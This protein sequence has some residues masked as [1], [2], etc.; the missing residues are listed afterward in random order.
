M[1]LWLWKCLSL[2]ISSRWEKNARTLF[3]RYWGDDCVWIQITSGWATCRNCP[4]LVWAWVMARPQHSIRSDDGNGFLLVKVQINVKTVVILHWATNGSHNI[5]LFASRR[6]LQAAS[7]LSVIDTNTENR[8]LIEVRLLCTATG[9]LIDFPVSRVYCPG[10]L[11]CCI[12]GWH[13]NLCNCTNWLVIVVQI[14]V[15]CT[16]ARRLLWT[17]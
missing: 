16:T 2:A 4:H 17:P 6:C 11:L 10:L 5:L 15:V 9:N 1:L 8:R 7:A 3:A 14:L 12:F 13:P